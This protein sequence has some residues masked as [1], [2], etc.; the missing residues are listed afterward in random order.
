VTG[1]FAPSPTGPLHLGSLLAALASCLEART[2]GG[3]W[4]LRIDDLD[5]PRCM[6][7]MADAHQRA[8][9]AFGF[10]WDEVPVYQSTRLGRYREALARLQALGLAY[11]CSCSRRE[12]AN[13]REGGAYPGT[14]RDRGLAGTPSV[15]VALRYRYDRMPVGPFDDLW[16]GQC[17]PESGDQGDPVVARRDGLPAYQL[18]V[19]L[20]D[21]DCNVTH[22]VRGADLLPSTFWQRSLQRA[23]DLPEPRYGHIPLLAEADGS[24]LAKSRHSLPLEAAQA[25][26]LLCQ[27]LALLG[28]QPPAELSASPVVEIWRWALTNW[29]VGYVPN[30]TVL[31]LP[32]A[33]Y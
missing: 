4:L 25:P 22:V 23:L 29:K 9:E 3:R 17:L 24:K 10:E 26:R 8:L 21:F 11:G 16:Q 7:G 27:A 30:R 2:R 31:A 1:R 20:D 6:P 33:L 13:G 28:Q 5:A 12:L 19:V 14:C 32:A 18:A 15:P